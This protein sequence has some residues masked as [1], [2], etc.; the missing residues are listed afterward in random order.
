[1]KFDVQL[2]RRIIGEKLFQ[3]GIIASLE[4][5]GEDD[6][7]K[8]VFFYNL[9]EA[10]FNGD[11]KLFAMQAK[12]EYAEAKRYVVEKL[13]SQIYKELEELSFHSDFGS[14]SS[15]TS[16]RMTTTSQQVVTKF[17]V[18]IN[19]DTSFTLQ[20]IECEHENFAINN[21]K[22]YLPYTFR[23]SYNFAT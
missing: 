1:M 17:V 10:G 18:M 5:L 2:K 13:E 11:S 7:S 20:K 16:Y 4:L 6:I 9:Q 14:E 22:E 19:A 12:S 8:Q 23:R 21:F 15:F 3:F